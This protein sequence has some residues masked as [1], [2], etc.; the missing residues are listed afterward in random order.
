MKKGNRIA[1]DR[2]RLAY[3]LALIV[4][5]LGEDEK[6]MTETIIGGRYVLMSVLKKSSFRKYVM[7]E[8]WSTFDEDTLKFKGE[9]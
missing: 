5:A 7:G 2:R 8:S 3:A 4:G 9:E 1:R 6:T